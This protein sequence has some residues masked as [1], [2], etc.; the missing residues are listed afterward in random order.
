L[1]TPFHTELAVYVNQNDVDGAN[2]VI[3]KEMGKIAVHHRGDFVDLLTNSDVPANAQFADDQLMKLYF[4]NINKREMLIGTA[5]LV[6]MHNKVSGFDGKDEINDAA[7]KSSYK[8]MSNFFG[9]IE[10]I[11]NSKGYIEEHQFDWKYSNLFGSAIVKG[12]VNVGKK[13]KANNDM[14]RS[15]EAEKKAIADKKAKTLKTGLIIGGVVV[16]LSIIGLLIY[17]FKK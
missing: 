8:V 16:G 5:L 12:A 1:E 2:A 11:P 14:K 17:K 7:T 6:N 15:M 9:G 13:L 4:D 10:G 3:M